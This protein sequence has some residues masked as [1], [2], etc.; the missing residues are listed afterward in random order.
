MS[1]AVG[2]YHRRS[3]Y[4][5]YGHKRYR[6][7]RRHRFFH[8]PPPIYNIKIRQFFLENMVST[9]FALS[10][11]GVYTFQLNSYTGTSTDRDWEWK[12]R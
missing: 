3:H 7:S 9:G 11:G 8:S 4:R 2:R 5:R 10:V 12:K 6:L 1:Y